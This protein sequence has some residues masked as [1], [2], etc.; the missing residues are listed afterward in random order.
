[1]KK[2]VGLLLCLTMFC[3]LFVGCAEGEPIV[4]GELVLGSALPQP[5]LEKGKIHTNTEESLW[6]DLNNAEKADYSSYLAQCKETFN[7]DSTVIG[8]SFRA[9]NSDGYKIDLDYNEYDGYIS[10]NLDAPL[11]TKNLKW[12]LNDL[13]E[14]LPTPKSTKGKV[15]WEHDDKF[16]VYVSDMT[17][18]D[19]DDYVDICFDAGF[20]VDYDKGETYY[21]AKN[22]QDYSLSLE[23]EGFNTIR[24]QLE[25]PNDEEESSATIS[26]EEE[27]ESKETQSKAE[28]KVSNVDFKKAM[29]EYEEFMDEYV[30]FMKKY[31]DSDGTD[32]SLLT[33]YATYMS[34]YAETVE[35]FENWE[36]EELTTDELAYYVEVQSRVTKKLLEVSQ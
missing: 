11:K 27:P 1:M 25:A 3:S 15:E 30:A 16:L 14:L 18:D 29:D 19:Y 26:K 12:P 24:I 9:Y 6:M 22:S 2:L 35:S 7:I 17:I 33:D 32:L 21:R 31:Q 13:C 23:Y 8:D 34:K 5:T 10:I 20:D 36:D 28:D 4:W